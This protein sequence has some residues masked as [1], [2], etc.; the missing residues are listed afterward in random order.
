MQKSAAENGQQNGVHEIDEESKESV[1]IIT[2]LLSALYGQLN[3]AS[4]AEGLTEQVKL[5]RTLILFKKK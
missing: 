2:A 1:Y 5:M 3:A 4:Y